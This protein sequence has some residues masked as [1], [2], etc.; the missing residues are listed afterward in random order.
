MTIGYVVMVTITTWPNVIRYTSQ[1]GRRPDAYTQG[2]E[3]EAGCVTGRRLG[4][5]L[6]RSVPLGIIGDFA[7][8]KSDKKRLGPLRLGP[9]SVFP[10]RHSTRVIR[11]RI[12]GPRP[13]VYRGQR[14]VLSRVKG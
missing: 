3:E 13:D 9:D 12:G 7:N 8:G 2:A 5:G 14:G 6:A 4:A 1:G 11:F 10:S